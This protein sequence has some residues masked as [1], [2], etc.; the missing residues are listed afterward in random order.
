MTVKNEIM[1]LKF[2]PLTIDRWADY[3]V[4]FGENGAC[5]GCWCMYWR[6]ANKEFEK[7]KGAGLKQ[8]MKELVKKGVITGLI[9]YDKQLPIGWISVA[10]REDYPRMENARVIKRIDNKPVWSVAC[11]FLNKKYRNKGV[12]SQL[13]DAA[14]E[15]VKKNKGKIVEGYPHLPEKKTSDAFVFMGLKSAFEKAGFKEVARPSDRRA[16]VRKYIK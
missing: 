7:H 15:Y 16:I 12:S 5:G 13:L 10:P 8:K 14:V 3:E 4:L 2:Y 1:K 11:I 6:V 9:A